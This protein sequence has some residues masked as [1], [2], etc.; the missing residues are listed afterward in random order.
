MPLYS[1]GRGLQNTWEGGW[2]APAVGLDSLDEKKSLSS[3]R[4][5][6]AIP[7]PS[8]LITL[9]IK[10]ARRCYLRQPVLAL[11]TYGISP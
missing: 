4:N 9:L 7:R 3:V 11:Q 6:T 8:S 10:L 2:V 5:R 1:R